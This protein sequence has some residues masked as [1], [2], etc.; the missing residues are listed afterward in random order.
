VTG[1]GRDDLILLWFGGRQQPELAQ[2]VILAN[3]DESYRLWLNEPLAGRNQ[4]VAEL[5]IAAAADLTGD[6][7]ADLVVQGDAGQVWVV[8]AVHDAPTLLPLA[9]DC[10]GDPR[11]LD[12][13]GDGRL[14][15]LRDHCP[16]DKRLIL[17][18]DNNSAAFQPI[19]PDSN[20]QSQ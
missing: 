1:D 16:T 17:S 6:G 12:V 2:L 13:N 8:T 7:R 10:Q 14:D 15:I 9:P 5:S 19:N 4:S 18:W 20:L 3:D 11:L